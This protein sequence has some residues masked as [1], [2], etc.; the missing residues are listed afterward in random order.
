MNKWLC[1]QLM[2]SPYKLLTA[3]VLSDQVQSLAHH[4]L[5]VAGQC[6]TELRAKAFADISLCSKVIGAR[7]AVFGQ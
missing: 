7:R 3:Y 2:H 5:L 4:A 6:F 1:P